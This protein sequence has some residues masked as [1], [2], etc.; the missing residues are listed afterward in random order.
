M[1]AEAQK[2]GP[3]LA[4]F[5]GHMQEAESELEQPEHEPAPICDASSLLHGSKLP[6]TLLTGSHGS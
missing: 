3:F 4:A 1:D 2:R 6:M 5:S